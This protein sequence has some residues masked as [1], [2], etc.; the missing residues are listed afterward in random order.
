MLRERRQVQFSPE[1]SK[2]ISLQLNVLMETQKPFLQLG[3]SL[4]D[5]ARQMEIP[6]YQLSAFINME[7]GAN[8][9]ELINKQRIRYCQEII[10]SGEAEPLNLFGLG[11]KCGFSNRNTF[12]MAFKKFAGMTPSEFLKANGR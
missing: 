4:R 5:L 11:A 6:A 12:T 8:F 9:N 1:Q 3:Y 10:K 2:N 7:T